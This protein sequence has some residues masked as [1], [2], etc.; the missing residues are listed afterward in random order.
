MRRWAG[1]ALAAT[2]IAAYLS[3]VPR[4]DSEVLLARLLPIL[5]FLITISLVVNLSAQAGVFA[6]VA[7]RAAK[8]TGGR[9]SALWLVVVSLSV[10]TTAFL[11][12]DS[13]AVLVTPLAIAMAKASRSNTMAL[14]FTI[15]WIANIGSLFLPV[16]N[17]TNLLAT[18]TSEVGSTGQFISIAWAPAVSAVAV[19]IVFSYLAFRGD[20]AGRDGAPGKIEDESTQ[21]GP[22]TPH[23][24]LRVC[25]V[26]LVI[27]LPLLAT[28]VPF[29]LSTSVAAAVL[30]AAFARFDR[31][32]LQIGLVPWPAVALATVLVLVVQLA[33]SLG[34]QELVQ[35]TFHD[36][37]GSA[38][39]LFGLAIAG[40]VVSNFINNIPAYLL[41]EPAA[42]S[43]HELIALLIGTNAGPIV[44]PWASLATL[45]WAD[46]LRRAGLEVPWR[47]YIALSAVLMPLAVGIPTLVLVILSPS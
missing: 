15:V 28:S 3:V 17:L 33:H 22:S 4:H 19:V 12:L 20:L 34:A 37:G 16:S 38:G 26:V 47:K 1:A 39:G 9:H 10:V 24:L 7:A 32:S 36:D 18:E 13:T 31:A 42:S 25:A 27:L 40:A 41:L 5:L 21:I 11:S 44:T 35:D 6:E 30:L 14:A 45:L 43:G 46:Q 29:W 23:Q 2:G 8:W